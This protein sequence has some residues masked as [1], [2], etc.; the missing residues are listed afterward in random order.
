MP[1]TYPDLAVRIHAQTPEKFLHKVAEVIKD[2][3][4]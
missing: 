3:Q 1:I 2:G 4:G